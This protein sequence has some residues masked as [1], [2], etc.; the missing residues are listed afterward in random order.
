MFPAL[1]T[2][3]TNAD[4][5]AENGYEESEVYR[6]VAE[7]KE[8]GLIRFLSN[9][10]TPD[11]H[12]RVRS[13]R[14]LLLGLGIVPVSPAAPTCSAPLTCSDAQP[15]SL[16]DPRL[17]DMALLPFA[18]MAL[19]RVLR[20]RDKLPQYNTVSDAIELLRRSKNIIVLS[21]AGISTSCGIPDFRSANGLYAQLQEEGKFDLDDPQQMF[22]IHFFR[23][24]P[25]VF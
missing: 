14:K 7:L 18:K 8:S 9:Y 21:G 10:I 13:L 15:G 24:H 22:D 1:P 4:H 23:E 17:P 19:S 20:R 25:E 6:M 11:S 5:T 3:R 2:Y 12:G 16:R